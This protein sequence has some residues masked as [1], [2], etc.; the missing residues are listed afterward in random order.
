MCHKLTLQLIISHL[1]FANSMLEGLPASSIKVMQK[2][3]NT[4]ARLILGEMLEKAS[5]SALNFT[6]ATDKTKDRLQNI[7]LLSTNVTKEKF[8][9]IFK[10]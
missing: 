1:D 2:I 4:A 6:L 8:Q 10:I 7:V 3:Q 5:W 9:Y